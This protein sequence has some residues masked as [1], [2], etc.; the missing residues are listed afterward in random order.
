MHNQILKVRQTGA[1]TV[2]V[3]REFT[4]EV[5]NHVAKDP[6]LLQEW[7]AKRNPGKHWAPEGD[8]YIV[9]EETRPVAHRTEAEY[10]ISE[11]RREK[12]SR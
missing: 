7:V 6:Q 8:P 1:R 11:S 4:I 2:R 9:I 3:F 12:I 10:P 5:P